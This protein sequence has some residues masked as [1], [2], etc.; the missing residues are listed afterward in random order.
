[1]VVELRRGTSI[2]H[3]DWLARVFGK[4]LANGFFSE[5][6]PIGKS[7]NHRINLG[8]FMVGLGGLEPPTSPLSGLRSLVPR[9][10]FTL[11]A[12]FCGAAICFRR[13][14]NQVPVPQ[15]SF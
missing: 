15:R 6:P 7:E 14:T 2:L 1:M 4:F 11:A 10:E 5:Y 13:F 3:L 12:F 8:K 9:E